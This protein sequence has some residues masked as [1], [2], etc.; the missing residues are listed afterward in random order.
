L[1]LRVGV[2]VLQEEL[3][4]AVAQV[5]IELQLELLVVVLVQNPL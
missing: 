5:A 4:A 3:V 2:V 1:L